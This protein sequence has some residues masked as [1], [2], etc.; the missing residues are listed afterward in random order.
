M[1]KSTA[2]EATT[3]GDLMET[4]PGERDEPAGLAALSDEARIKVGG[5]D[6]DGILRGKSI[7]V[8]KFRSACDTGFG[9]CDVIF[10]WDSQDALY[11]NARFT[12]WHTGYP[13]VLAR[14]D[15]S[16]YRRVPWEG[17]VPFFLCDFHGK[18]DA[19]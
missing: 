12:G 13:D 15:L 4:A 14:V 19:L 6:L 5:F 3:A 10:G 9:F 11:D 2:E 18:D 1:R 7:S 8:G 17:N 16:T